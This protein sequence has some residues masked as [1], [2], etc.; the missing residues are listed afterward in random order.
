M[1]MSPA[2]RRVLAD[3]KEHLLRWNPQINLVSRKSTDTIV[4]GLIE[5][6]VAGIEATVEYLLSEEGAAGGPRTKAVKYFDLGSGG[7][8]PGI[9]WHWRLAELGF[10]PASC[11]VEPRA[12]RAWFLERLG[13][14]PSMPPFTVLCDRWGDDSGED[15]PSCPGLGPIAAAAGVQA[16]TILISLKALKLTDKQVLAGLARL[17]ADSSLC[18]DRILIAR[19]YPPEQAMDFELIEQLGLPATGQSLEVSGLE[20]VAAK[21]WVA[22]LLGER[23]PCAALVYS[24][25]RLK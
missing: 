22:P 1:A 13:N 23:G 18:G 10:V 17:A 19:Y 3:F 16:T 15:G 6:G 11:F 2:T 7:G 21:S 12:K 8:I 5:Q 20:S 24:E 14:I 25:Y 4:D 9:V